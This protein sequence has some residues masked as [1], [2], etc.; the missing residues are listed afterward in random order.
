MAYGRTPGFGSAAIR[1]LIGLGIVSII[2]TV[3]G[4]IDLGK[5]A[6]GSHR[7]FEDLEATEFKVGDIVHGTITETLG[8][9]A[10]ETTTE[11]MMYVVETDKYTSSVYYVVPYFD[12]VDDPYPKKIILYKTGNKKQMSDL[13]KLNEETMYWYAQMRDST[14]THVTVDRAEIVEMNSQE[15]D[16]FYDYLE[17]FV[18]A[19]YKSQ[20]KQTRDYLKISYRD[21]AIPYLIQYNAGG[22]NIM[23]TIGIVMLSI[24][25]IILIVVLLRMKRKSAEPQITY[26]GQTHYVG[27]DPNL[28]SPTGL[29]NASDRFYNNNAGAAPTGGTMDAVRPPQTPAGTSQTGVPPYVA[30][31]PARQTGMPPHLAGGTTGQAGLPPHLANSNTRPVQSGTY[32][33]DYSNSERPMPQINRPAPTAAPKRE[34]NFDPFTGK[35]IEKRTLIDAAFGAPN[36]NRN[37]QDL[38]RPVQ[39]MPTGDSM[40]SVDPKTEDNVDL[41]NGGISWEDRVQRNATMPKNGDVPVINPESYSAATMFGTIVPV[42]AE[43]HTPPPS[44]PEPEKPVNEVTEI[45]PPTKEDNI[46]SDFQVEE[47]DK[48]TRNNYSHM[49]GGQMNEVDPYTEKNVDLS[50]GGVEIPESESDDDLRRSFEKAMKDETPSASFPTAEPLQPS[51]PAQSDS[52]APAPEPVQPEPVKTEPDDYNIFKTG[53]DSYNIFKDSAPKTESTPNMG[54]PVESKDFPKVDTSFPEAGKSDVGGKDDF[55]F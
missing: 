35:P 12:S 20:D 21:A 4:M 39:P 32:R 45:H 40:P 25:I 41:S 31:G 37:M 52:P 19:Y 26:V 27:N 34:M 14:S 51:F 22:G 16:A 43:T 1:L 17:E 7:N 3:M 2:L 33:T 6:F 38:R 50:N 9:A 28:N 36:A 15:K 23:L 44:V 24:F 30:A 55:I 8:C 54:F 47:T 10:T 11:T 49:A 13:E 53:G 42:E 5:D 46:K 48:E 18:D 29:T